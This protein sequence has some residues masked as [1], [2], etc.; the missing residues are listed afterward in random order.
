[1]RSF[2]KAITAIIGIAFLGISLRLASPEISNPPVTSDF[3]GPD[4]IAVIFKHACYDCHSNETKLAWFDKVAPVSW[5][6]ASHV[7]EGRKHLNLS[8]WDS[9]S[10]SQQL[11]TLW[12]MVNMIDQGRMPLESYASVHPG[13]KVSA[14]ELQQLKRYVVAL[15]GKQAAAKPNTSTTPAANKLT[16]NATPAVVK[17]TANTNTTTHLSPNGIEYDGD[18]RNWQVIASTNRI[19]N[20][21]MRVIYGND[22]AVKAIK[23]NKITPWPDGARI[24]KVVWNKTPED[25]EGNV[26]PGAFNNIQYMIRDARKYKDTGG[27]GYARFS[28]PELIPYGKKADFA[29]ECSNCHKLAEKQGFVFDIPTHQLDTSRTIANN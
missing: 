21:T 8:K 14:I 19:D 13:A 1:M 24:A 22:I 10:P 5:L 15:S 12:Y 20:G 4:S 7:E 29:T 27:W 23:E 3:T 11:S 28:T 18:F 16:N 26:Y 6:V 9:L 17:L 2:A 25:A